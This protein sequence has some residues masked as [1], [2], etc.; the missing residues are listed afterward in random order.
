MAAALP[1]SPGWPAGTAPSQGSRSR[2]D[3][4]Q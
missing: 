1:R 2:R 3:D 4:S